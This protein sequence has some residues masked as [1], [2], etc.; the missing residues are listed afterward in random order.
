[1]MNEIRQFFSYIAFFL[2]CG[3]FNLIIALFFREI[4][5]LFKHLFVPPE[6][7]VAGN[8]GVFPE[9]YRAVYRRQSAKICYKFRRAFY[10]WCPPA[11]WF[12]LY[13]KWETRRILRHFEFVGEG[14]RLCGASLLLC[15]YWAVCRHPFE[16][17]MHSPDRGGVCGAYLNANRHRLPF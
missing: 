9:F 16:A 5:Y 3:L 4:F 13:G 12:F 14:T 15:S 17:Q 6:S 2:L 10:R 1:M 11:R 7:Q 8:D